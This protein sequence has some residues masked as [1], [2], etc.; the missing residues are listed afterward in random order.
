M[1]FTL[2]S[3][4]FTKCPPFPDEEL[5]FGEVVQ[6][7]RFPSTPSGPSADPAPICFR[8]HSQVSLS[9]PFLQTTMPPNSRMERL[10]NETPLS[11]CPVSAPTPFPPPPLQS[12]PLPPGAVIP[13]LPPLHRI[14]FLS[15]S[16]HAPSART[17][18]SGEYF[19]SQTI[20]HCL[21]KFPH[22]SC[23]K[24]HNTFSNYSHFLASRFHPFRSCQLRSRWTGIYLDGRHL[25]R[26]LGLFQRT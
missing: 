8:N 10:S 5:G 18:N 12:C 21:S 24:R 16:L 26:Y 13:Q 9:P 1:Y 25:S 6:A 2:S 14:C 15:L 11:V 7:T 20:N 4:R 3:S 19:R 22:L 23:D 17:S